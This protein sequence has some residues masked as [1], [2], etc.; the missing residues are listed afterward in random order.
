MFLFVVCFAAVTWAESV[1]VS[2][3][4][5]DC[6]CDLTQNSCDLY[7]CCDSDCSALKSDWEDKGKCVGEKVLPEGQK[8]EDETEDTLDAGWRGMKVATD[9]INRLLCVYID[10][11]PS[12]FNNFEDIGTGS[13]GRDYN[14]NDVKL[15]TGFENPGTSYKPGD[16][17]YSQNGDYEYPW[18][19]PSPGPFGLCSN[20]EPVQFLVSS[21]PVTCQVLISSSS[22]CTSMGFDLYVKNLNIPNITPN[23]TRVF[24]KSEYKLIELSEKEFTTKF[25]NWDC[26]NAVV[27]ANYTVFSTNQKTIDKIE[28]ELVI[29]DLVSSQFNYYEQTHQV[30]FLTN[31][32]SIFS[33]S[34]NPGYQ[35]GKPVLS[36]KVISETNVSYYENGF[37]VPG[38]DSSGQCTTESWYQSPVL[39]FG[40]DLI[41][42]CYKELNFSELKNFCTDNPS[43]PVLFFNEDL[44]SHLGK[45]GK[46][47]PSY[48]DDW[49]EIKTSSK[50]E[51]S[52]D[53]SFGTCTL[54]NT[55]A[56][57][58]VYAN[59]GNA[60]NPQNKII[61]ASREYKEK[62]YWIFK[63][64][65]KAKKQKFFYTLTV[66]FVEYEKNT[67]VYYP[68]APNPLPV[69]PDD[70]MYPFK[71]SFANGM[72]MA[73]A[74]VFV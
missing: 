49:V 51:A 46:I 61:Y 16:F 34:G 13:K 35:I 4:F 8:C 55:L 52:F 29:A 71:I 63:N 24:R 64:K 60:R 73:A 28:V 48:E 38:V 70:I 69:M 31:T 43:D 59:I 27:Q 50:S 41:V 57:Y 15:L 17:I 1:S 68:P 14:T 65:D 67:Y 42:N 56:Y 11:S 25:D 40:E 10:N 66:N 37:K 5:A 12:E 72:L 53:E 3:S 23:V 33:R 54:Q 58:V 2:S 9:M 22:D 44:V 47:D 19:M 45:F 32:S 62:T 39:T 6:V 30:R 18:T 26:T 74:F 20:S 36:G 21:N 7:C